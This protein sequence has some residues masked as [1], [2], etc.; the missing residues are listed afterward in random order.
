MLSYSGVPALHAL[1]VSAGIIRNDIIREEVERIRDEV[2]RG[3]SISKTMEK[4]GLFN[5]FS[6]TMVDVG[7][8]S[9]EIDTMMNRVADFYDQELNEFYARAERIGP[10]I[11]IVVMSVLVGTI[12]VALYLPI[13]TIIEALAD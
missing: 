11:I 5:R 7:E 8:R 6:V 13:L 1:K 10:A 12:I 9:G 3:E 2:A 4:G